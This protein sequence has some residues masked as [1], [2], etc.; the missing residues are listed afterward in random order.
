M[1][2]EDTEINVDEIDI[3]QVAVEDEV[4]RQRFDSTSLE[5]YSVLELD[6]HAACRRRV[7]GIHE[8]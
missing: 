4:P 3:D 2:N 6:A 8:E 7:A 5:K 1:T